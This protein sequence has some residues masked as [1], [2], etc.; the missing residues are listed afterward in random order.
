MKIFSSKSDVSVAGR[1]TVVSGTS[2]AG[3]TT[4]MVSLVAMLGSSKKVKPDEDVAVHTMPE[5][6]KDASE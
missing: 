5:P 3:K 6:D 2:G 1:N 4:L